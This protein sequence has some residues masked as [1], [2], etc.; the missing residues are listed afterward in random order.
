[1]VAY[2]DFSN[3]R[4]I[5]ITNIAASLPSWVLGETQPNHNNNHPPK[6]NFIIFIINNPKQQFNFISKMNINKDS[7]QIGEIT[8]FSSVACRPNLSLSAEI[9][10]FSG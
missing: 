1:M 2:G 5:I 7:S 10:C 8:W 9:N 6:L 3:N 4:S